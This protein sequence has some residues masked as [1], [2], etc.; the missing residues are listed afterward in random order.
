MPRLFDISPPVDSRLAV[1]PGDTPPTREILLDMS[2][3]DP[4]TLSS[5]HSTVHLGAH[6]DAPSHYGRDGASI[7]DQPLDLFLGPARLVRVSLARGQVIT[8]DGVEAALEAGD[9]SNLPERILIATGTYPDPRV[10]NTDYAPVDPGLVDWLAER[11]VR[12]IGVDTPS[13]DASDSKT[14]PAHNAMLRNG[15][16]ILEGLVLAGVPD[17]TYELIALPLRLVG[18]DGSPVRAVLRTL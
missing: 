11:G 17:G 5:L 8:I 16:S 4:I 12:L 3:G 15:M 14:L 2:R 7:D 18:F 10:F 9:E 6:V 1:F 13:V